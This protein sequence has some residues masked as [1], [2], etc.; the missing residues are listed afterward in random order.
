M[1]SG[2]Q[3]TAESRRKHMSPS[4]LYGY[5]LGSTDESAA[6]CTR[7]EQGANVSCDLVIYR[8][9]GPSPATLIL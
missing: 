8:T 7:R 6:W 9:L 2:H 4:S 5:K 3:I 1:I